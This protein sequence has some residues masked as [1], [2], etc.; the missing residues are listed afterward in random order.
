MTELF[1]YYSRRKSAVHII[2]EYR[3]EFFLLYC[4]RLPRNIEAP[5][6]RFHVIAHI[7]HPLPPYTRS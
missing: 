7:E 3:E 1:A 5:P 4:P 2:V 6:S